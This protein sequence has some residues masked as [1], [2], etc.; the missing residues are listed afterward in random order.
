MNP[1]NFIAALFLLSASL[2]TLTSCGKDDEKIRTQIEN[3]ITKGTWH[4][5]NFDDS[6]VDKTDNFAGYNFT[7]SENG[8]VSATN[9]TLTYT[10]TWGINDG[11]EDDDIL[12]DLDF[13]LN[14][15]QTN[16]FGDLTD[17]WDIFAQSVD[18]LELV[19]AG[20]LSDS[21]L[22]SFRKN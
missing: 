19:E 8:V 9:G 20:G 22:L 21:D 14:F 3:N 16:A 11:D 13:N 12:D 7:F 2:L 18:N 17:D 4:V 5:S 1:R 15:T 10:G 6:N